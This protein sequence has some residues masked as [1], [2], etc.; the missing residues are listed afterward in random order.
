MAETMTKLENLINPQVMADMIRAKVEAKIRVLP[1]A[2]VD[3]TL[4]GTAGDTVTLPKFAYIGDA[5][6]VAEG[7]EIPTRQM[8]VTSDTYTIK[9]AGIGG[10]ITDK[11]LLCGHGN[12]V[13]ELTSQIATS[14]ASKCDNDAMEELYTASN[15]YTGT[16]TI[17]YNEVVNACDLFNEEEDNDKVMFIHPKQKTQ[18]RLDP[19]FISKEKYGGEVMVKGEIGMVAGCHVKVSKKVKLDSAG[20]HYLN[21]IVKLEND[22]EAEDDSPALTYFIKRETNVEKER[23]SKRRT[24]EI[25]GDQMYTV[26]LTNETKVVIAKLPKATTV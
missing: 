10:E 14:I 9:M 3:N 4:K 5:V 11:A 2:K 20:T 7:E 18:L 17:C 26:A 8:A 21:P 15:T 16:K 1:Y 13:G 23:H 12:P 6:D 22:T 24:T 25:T 19:D